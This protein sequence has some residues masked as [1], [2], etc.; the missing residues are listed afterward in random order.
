MAFVNDSV[1]DF[2]A[3]I[4]N[5]QTAHHATVS[6]PGSKLKRAMAEIL[7]R[8]GYIA[9]AEW[10]DEGPQ[11]FIDITLKY[12]DEDQPMIT[13]LKRISKASRR[14]YVG[15]GEIP[16]V[17]NGLGIAILSTS[18]GVLT[19]KEARASNVGGEVLC[20]IY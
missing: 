5:A 1:A 18:K 4:R 16:K 17:L 15:V 14:R 2:L 7:E 9:S 10:R 13:S 3:R 8:Y 20:E 11:G 6:I 12:D 19:D